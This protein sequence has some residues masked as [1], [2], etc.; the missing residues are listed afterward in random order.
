MYEKMDAMP[1]TLITQ[2]SIAFVKA[3][4]EEQ[5]IDL[6]AF[7]KHYLLMAGLKM[8]GFALLIMV[9]PSL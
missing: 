6:D 4:Y 7:Q 1:D 5:G 9:T 2:G 8:H 3:E